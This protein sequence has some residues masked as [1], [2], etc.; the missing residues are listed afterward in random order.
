MVGV[1]NRLGLEVS[2]VRADLSACHLPAGSVCLVHCSLRG[3]GR[4]AEG[5]ATLARALKDVLGP[6]STIVVP[7]FT[8][9]NSTTTRRFRLL[10]A[11]MT[12]EEVADEETKIEAFDRD[13][14]PAQDVGAFAEFIRRHPSAVRSNHPQTSFA[15]VGPAARALTD[16]HALDCHLGNR[17]P[18]GKLYA[19][20]AIVLLLGIAA[21][22]F[23]DVCTCFHLAEHRLPTAAPWRLYRA[24]V[25]EAGSRALREFVAAELDDSDFGRIGAEMAAEAAFV[26]HGHV[27][28]AAAIWFPLRAAVDFAATWMARCRS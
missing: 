15:A 20:D 10:T 2:E 1:L 22:G 8:A 28:N 27:G 18:L 5:P 16:G 19:A 21:E 12:A 24:Y 11:G 4:L 3:V 25:A 7:A 17:S 13:T 14:T 23:G 6:R 9:R 26:R